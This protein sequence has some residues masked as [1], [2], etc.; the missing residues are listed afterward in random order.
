MFVELLARG[1]AFALAGEPRPLASI[2]VN[3]VVEMPVVLEGRA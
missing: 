2:L 3:G 1:P